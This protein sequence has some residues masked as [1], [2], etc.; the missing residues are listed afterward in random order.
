MLHVA[1]PFKE[2][3]KCD[4]R[5]LSHASFSSAS[6]W[7]CKL[8]AMPQWF[9]T[10]SFSD[11]QA[12]GDTV[13]VAYRAGVRRTGTKKDDIKSYAANTRQALAKRRRKIQK[14]ASFQ[15]PVIRCCT[16]IS[17][18]DSLDSAIRAIHCYSA[19][20]R[21]RLLMLSIWFLRRTVKEC[22]TDW[23]VHIWTA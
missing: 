13:A 23:G 20:W 21:Q 17:S 11:A 9:I 1:L 5:Q 18:K 16:V 2:Q 6:C 3:P 15:N 10:L 4:V 12:A 7:L 14:G 8:Y 19:L 22:C